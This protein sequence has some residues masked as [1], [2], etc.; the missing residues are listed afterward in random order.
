MTRTVLVVCCIRLKLVK[1][2]NM[3]KGYIQMTDDGRLF[4][5]PFIN[6]QEQENGEIARIFGNDSDPLTKNC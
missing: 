4:I 6:V 1:R 5:F 3:Q 2:N